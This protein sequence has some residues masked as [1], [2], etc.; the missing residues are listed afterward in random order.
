MLPI[1]WLL[2]N[3]LLAVLFIGGCIFIM[4]QEI[5]DQFGLAFPA[6][7]IY[8]SMWSW[9]A[10][11]MKK[12]RMKNR[13]PTTPKPA[14][15]KRQPKPQPVPVVAQTLTAKAHKTTEHPVKQMSHS[16]P[17]TLRTLIE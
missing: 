16:L 11:Y 10:N 14:K 7:V 15:K 1:A 13:K 17:E 6:I 9:A 2:A 12:W 3:P 4:T 5:G 8:L